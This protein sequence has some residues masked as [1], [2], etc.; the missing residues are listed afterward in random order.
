MSWALGDEGESKGLGLQRAGW[1]VASHPLWGGK[2]QGATGRWG[3][4]GRLGRAETQR[5]LPRGLGLFFG[6]T[7]KNF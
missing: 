1:E 7:T 2:C 5:D 3:W 4:T 6:G